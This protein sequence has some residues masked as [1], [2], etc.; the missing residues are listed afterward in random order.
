MRVGY[1]VEKKGGE[2][3]ARGNWGRGR[4]GGVYIHRWKKKKKKKKK[5]VISSV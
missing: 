3:G 1:K 4:G 5:V 2:R